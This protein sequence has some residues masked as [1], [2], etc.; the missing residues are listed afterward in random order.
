MPAD[1]SSLDAANSCSQ[2][3]T[4]AARFSIASFKT[5][6][7]TRKTVKKTQNTMAH[8]NTPQVECT[9]DVLSGCMRARYNMSGSWVLRYET[10]HF[11]T[12]VGTCQD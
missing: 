9:R 3:A 6:C 7:R 5:V 12:A 4:S 11:A 10:D 1:F 8:V 2:T